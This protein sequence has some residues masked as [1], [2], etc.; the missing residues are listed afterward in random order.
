MG[1]VWGLQRGSWGEMPEIYVLWR[2][3]TSSHQGM[4]RDPEG[5]CGERTKDQRAGINGERPQRRQLKAEGGLRGGRW[6]PAGG[7]GRCVPGQ[8]RGPRARPL[9]YPQGVT[10][11]E[12][13]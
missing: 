10:V 8:D 12:G 4:C 13:N 5:R 1:A 2:H 7:P 11:W 6:S 9:G 3:M